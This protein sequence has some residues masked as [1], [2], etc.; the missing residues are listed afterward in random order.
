MNYQLPSWPPDWP[1]L[2]EAVDRA[3]NSGDW[4]RYHSKICIDLTRRLKDWF[5]ADAESNGA[6]IRLCCSGNAALEL[7][8]R[9]AKVGPG[10]EVLISAY[11][12]PGNLR[13]IELLGAKP[14]LL[15]VEPGSLAFSAAQ[16]RAAA[17]RDD[18]KA[19]R[20]VI[21]SHL[22]GEVVNTEP[23]RS[24]CDEAG[25]FL[26][27]DV[28]QSLGARTPARTREEVAADRFSKG[29]SGDSPSRGRLAGSWGHL[30]TF[31][32]GGSKP[33]SAGSGG[34]LLVNDSRLLAGAGSWLE[35]PGEVYPLSPLQSVV[36]GPQLDRL[37]EL[38]TQ[39]NATWSELYRQRGG[40]YSHWHWM[41]PIQPGV[42][43]NPYKIAW[44]AESS[45]A[46]SRV[47]RVAEDLG[48]PIGAGYRSFAKC[49]ARR[50][51]KFGESEQ[52][53]SL[54]ERLFVLDHRSLLVEPDRVENLVAA[55]DY[56]HSHFD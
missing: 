33:V 23:M 55:L 29:K 36:L 16:L 25:W 6:E 28:C 12:Y 4:G 15:D 38:Q 5:N 34:A 2:R 44:L 41:V 42:I 14:V 9:A 21:V 31:S 10:D 27:E 18:T 47:I 26:I 17:N 52:S 19:I 22:F 56:V 3:F 49:S 50:C 13:T 11:D 54:G 35:R 24:V 40:D 39:R 45:E 48:L 32:F 46:R 7:A 53:A 51:R 30:A 43:A 37:E 1:E 20:A 8:L